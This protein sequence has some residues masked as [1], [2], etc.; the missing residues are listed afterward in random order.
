MTQT[1]EQ[2]RVD[3][4]VLDI[5]VTLD[6][7][8]AGIRGHQEQCGVAQALRR[9]GD[10][11]PFVDSHHVLA[12]GRRWPTTPELRSWILEFDCGRPIAPERFV[13]RTETPAG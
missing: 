13:L 11:E 9:M 12:F 1:I 5:V 3:T 10:T 7:I 6:D 4:D 2:V 8:K